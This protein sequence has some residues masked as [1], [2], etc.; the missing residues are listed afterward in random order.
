MDKPEQL[1]KT[2]Q[3]AEILGI[4]SQ[5]L[6]KWRRLDAPR[7]PRWVELSS[8]AIRY[9]RADID[10]YIRELAEGRADE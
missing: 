3:V 4:Q 6:R 8:H 2:E 7:G 1:L 10:A 9:R 5:T